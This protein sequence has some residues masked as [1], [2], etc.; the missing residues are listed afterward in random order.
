[1]TGT[2][3]LT[4]SLLIQIPARFP[5][6]RVWRTNTGGAVPMGI[7]R[8]A[9]AMIR[10]G[11]IEAGC[12]MLQRP[13]KFGILGGG[14]ISGV[15]GPSGR[16]LSIEVKWGADKQSE[17]QQAFEAMLRDRG[18][19]YLIARDVEGCLEALAA[20]VAAKAVGAGAA[21]AA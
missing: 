18:G 4:A 3:N 15:I 14:D 20:T 7:V 2:N 5:N 19:L 13:T 8:A 17:E 1:M 12:Q 21:G 6:I 9:V 11:K 16:V 10:T